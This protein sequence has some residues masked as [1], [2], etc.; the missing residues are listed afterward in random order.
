MINKTVFSALCIS[1]LSTMIHASR[2]DYTLEDVYTQQAPQE[3]NNVVD[4]AAQ[5]MH[6]SGNY[7][8]IIPKKAGMQINPWNQL[9]I[10][11]TNP[12]TKNPVVMINPEFFATLTNPEQ[13]F[14]TA[15]VLTQ[16]QE[17]VT[18]WAA[19]M[20]PW[21]WMMLSWFIAAML[22]VLITKY[23]RLVQY[24]WWGRAILV[25]ATIVIANMTFG[26][27]LQEKWRQYVGM[28]HDTYTHEL[29]IAKTGDREAAISALEKID[30]TIK[31]NIKNGEQF[32][33]PNENLFANLANALKKH[34]YSA[35]AGCCGGH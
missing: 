6:F 14:L 27:Q 15:R 3:L 13:I 2:V 28:K 23:T 19:K 32:F 16:A 7:E 31:T 35:H 34:E 18:P 12:M 11:T 33:K 17:G 30:A 25:W 29:V 1:I 24:P 5:I 22:F 9:V 21:I 20:I 26:M 4:N 8:V 10:L